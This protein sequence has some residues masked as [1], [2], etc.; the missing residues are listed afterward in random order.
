[1]FFAAFS[2]TRGD[3]ATEDTSDL[4]FPTGGQ[5]LGSEILWDDPDVDLSLATGD[6]SLEIPRDDS[7]G[8]FYEGSYNE[9]PNHDDDDLFALAITDNDWSR[10]EFESDCSLN[11]GPAVGKMRRENQCHSKK[12]S[13]EHRELSENFTFEPN[14]R[15]D[16]SSSSY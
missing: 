1:M 2:L 3:P 4:I 8:L 6:L 10:Y 16:R 15:P 9:Y 7:L 14:F 11:Q 5:I 12:N 13:E